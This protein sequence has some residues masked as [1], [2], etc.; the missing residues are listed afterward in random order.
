LAGVTGDFRLVSWNLA[1]GKPAAYKTVENRRR[2]WALLGALAPDIAL[3]QECRPPD[4]EEHAPEWMAR[5]YRCVGLLQ[6]GWRLSTS[7]LVREPLT[8]DAL[9]QTCLGA[10]ELRWLEHLSGCVATATVRAGTVEFAVASVHAAGTLKVGTAVTAEDHERLRRP[11]LV[12]ATTSDLLAA[13]LEP[14]VDRRRFLVGGDWNTSPLFDTDYPNTKWGKA[15]A[16]TEFFERRNRAGWCDA[17]RR[18]H[19]AELCTYLDPNT[20]PREIDRVFTDPETYRQLAGCHVLDD[21]AVTELSD[22]APL[23]VDIVI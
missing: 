4:L 18:F 7:M 17:M 8:V 22:H 2:Q 20:G 16:S 3:L 13:T 11:G 21:T 19:D 6:P 14:W 9:D 5:A 1:Y 23:V 12:L 10:A 15:R